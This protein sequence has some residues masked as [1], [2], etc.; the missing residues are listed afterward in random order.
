VACSN[1]DLK[2]YPV[3]ANSSASIMSLLGDDFAS[4]LT[5]IY[6]LVISLF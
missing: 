4:V 1:S 2:T 5:T 3:V 6:S